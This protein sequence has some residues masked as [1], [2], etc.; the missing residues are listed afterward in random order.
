MKELTK[1]GSNDVITCISQALNLDDTLLTNNE[2]EFWG[3]S[4][5]M[6]VISRALCLCLN[7]LMTISEVVKLFWK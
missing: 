5:N 4:K 3:N 1:G 2:K 7:M 6:N